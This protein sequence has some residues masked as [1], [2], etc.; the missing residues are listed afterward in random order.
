[1]LMHEEIP[2]LRAIANDP[3]DD[4][5]RLVYADWLQERGDPRAEYLRLEV[6]LQGLPIGTTDRKAALKKQIG[7]LQPQLDGS[8]EARLSWLRNLPQG[9]RL[10]L[11]LL[12]E[13]RGL[14]DVRGGQEDTVLLVE[15]KPVAL[16][17]D[18]CRGSVG[19]YLVFT[20]HTGRGDYMRQ[21]AELVAGEVDE[22]RPLAD[23]IEP[24]LTLFAAGTYSVIYTPSSAVES[25]ATF[26]YSNLS[27]ANRELVE[28]YPAEQRILICTQAR[29]SLNEERV[30]YYRKL[31]RAKQRPIVLTTSAEG[32]WCEFVI[33]GHH[34]LE[35]YVRQRVKPNIL[36]IER[37]QAP[38]ITLEEGLAML[39]RGHRGVAEYR[40]VKGR[41]EFS[42]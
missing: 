20:G 15:G 35:A 41:D 2:F 6:E 5:L 11:R 30:A 36:S 14:I 9:V 4:A 13:G 40:R 12:R 23:Q 17:W 34:K 28:Y 8:W 19:Q 3:H 21:L 10:D 39:P 29:E 38:A 32:T 16:N 31:I 24:L 7:D 26:E 37:W 18:D 33:D 22:S 1:M 42:S 27:S 25:W